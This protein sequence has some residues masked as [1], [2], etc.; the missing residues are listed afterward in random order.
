VGR[1]IFLGTGD[2]LNW[3]RA[4]ASLA[5]PLSDNEAMLIDASSGTVLL[6]QLEA[7]GIPLG[8][9]RHLFVT[10]RHF[11]H[12]G[13]LV[14]LL[15]AMAALPD[16]SLTVHAVPET[17]KALR[18]LLALTMPGVESWLGERLR[19]DELTSGKR[20][21]IGDTEVTPFEVDHGLG[22]VGFRVEQGGSA[23][24]YSA[25][26]RPCSN[27]IEHARGANLL[28]HEVYGL[29]VAAKEA[30]AFG[31][32]TAA[33][34]GKVV[35]DSRVCRLILTHVRERRFADPEALA[36]EAEAAL[37]GSVEVACDLATFKF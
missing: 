18:E 7:A 23:M 8:S 15:T 31:H 27:V 10:H 16:A 19:W 28:V 37:G 26:T 35:R 3:E 30:Y 13:G 4:Q 20:I 29:E 14:P 22:C 34:A 12:A 2:L 36:A 6:K 11:D 33:E 9:V 24:V 21:R 1:V 17:L 5:V 25:D 32:S